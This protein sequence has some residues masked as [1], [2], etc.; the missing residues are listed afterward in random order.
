MSTMYKKT[1]SVALISLL[2]AAGSAM[3]QTASPSPTTTT[4]P[5]TSACPINSPLPS[6]IIEV[7]IPQG[8]TNLGQNGFGTNPLAV[9]AGTVVIWV[10]DDSVPHTV[11][12]DSNAFDSGNLDPGEAF[13]YFFNSAG[14]FPYHC[15]LH[16]NMT[17]SV[18][19][20]SAPGSSP[21]PVPA[22]TNGDDSGGDSSGPTGY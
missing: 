4:S 22:V 3:A 17:G 14:T 7:R 11:T 8:A 6:N 10:N 9:P 20:G 13:A 5:G 21:T 19:V 18:T 12:S 2:V 16:P 1:A 15:T